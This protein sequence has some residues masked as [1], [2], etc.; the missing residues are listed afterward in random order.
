MLGFIHKPGLLD[1]RFWEELESEE[2]PGWSH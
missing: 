2:A 1:A